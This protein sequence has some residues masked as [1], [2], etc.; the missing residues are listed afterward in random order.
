MPRRYRKP[1]RGQVV[2]AFL[3]AVQRHSL[4]TLQIE[5]KYGQPTAGSDGAVLLTQRTRRRVARVGE[6]RLFVQLELC[7]ERVE[8]GFFHIHLAAHDQVRRRVFQLVRDI[9]YGL[10]VRGHVL[11]DLPVAARRAADEHPVHILERD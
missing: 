4:D 9:L 5:H 1:Q 6:Q 7:V 2:Q 8:H 3:V 11:A 10:E